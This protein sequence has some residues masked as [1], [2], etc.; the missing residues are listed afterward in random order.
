[1]TKAPELVTSKTH[2]WIAISTLQTGARC[3]TGK[4]GRSKP[5]RDRRP[6]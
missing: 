6:I 2:E 1:M 3:C 5:Q 4:K